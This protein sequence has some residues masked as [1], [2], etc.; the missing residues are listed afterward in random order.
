MRRR[1]LLAGVAASVVGVKS[2]GGASVSLVD[3][4]N[5]G[6]ALGAAAEAVG[7]LG[8]SVAHLASLGEQGWNTVSARRTRDRLRD[9]S[10][11]LTI[12]SAQQNA[13]VI[14]SLDEYIQEA[15]DGLSTNLLQ[16]AWSQLVSRLNETLSNVQALLKDLEIERSDLV[17]QNVYRDLVETLAARAGLLD[18][19]SKSSAPTSTDEIQSLQTAS[20][21]YK[22]FRENLGKAIEALNI[23][24]RGPAGPH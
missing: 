3:L 15:K 13:R 20:L 5:L 8:D 17:T 7:K 24:I 14:Q 1:T 19:L 10:A 4:S 9:I 16:T 12:L 18:K 11:R 23:Y 22:V 2:A 6:K 21:N